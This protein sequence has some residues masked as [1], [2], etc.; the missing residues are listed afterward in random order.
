M[1]VSPDLATV[2]SPCIGLCRLDRDGLCEGCLRSGEEIGAWSRMDE[3]QRRRLMEEVLQ[4][5]QR[6][7]QVFVQRL[8]ERDGLQRVLHPLRQPPREP[9]WNRDELADLLGPHA[10]AEA[11]VLVGLVPRVEGTRVLLTLRTDGLRHH[12]G[13][14]SFPGGRVEPADRGVLAAALRES[15]EEIALPVCQVAP[16]GYLDPLLTISGFRITPVVAAVDPD[17]VP[18]PEPGEVAQVFEVPLDYLMEPARLR[19]IDMDYRGRTRTV[20]EYDWPEQRIWGAT[21]AILYNLRRRL[22]EGR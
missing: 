15:H 13:Q 5:R 9:G 12:G 16:L 4:Q 20:L 19:R 11:A 14:V 2:S 21:A 8:R 7:R 22:E 17:F 3:G 1:S 6:Q 10:P 18:R